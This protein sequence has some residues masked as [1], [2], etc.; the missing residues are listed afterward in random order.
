MPDGGKRSADNAK[1]RSEAVRKLEQKEAAQ[2]AKAGKVGKPVPSTG[3]S[4]HEA[5]TGN[6]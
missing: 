6:A 3:R 2:D 1:V 4:I 5:I